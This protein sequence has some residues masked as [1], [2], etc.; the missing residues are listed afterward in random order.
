MTDAH[1][2]QG[3]RC[4]HAHCTSNIPTAT[5]TQIGG[6]DAGC[7]VLRMGGGGARTWPGTSRRGCHGDGNVLCPGHSIHSHPGLGIA[8]SLKLPLGEVGHTQ[9]HCII[10][11][12]HRYLYNYLDTKHLIKKSMNFQ[13]LFKRQGEGGKGRRETDRYTERERGR[14]FYPLA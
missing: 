7:R 6:R 13:D 1:V 14:L 11:Y 8:S 9:S 4:Q 3:G 12:N 2:S 5:T 10:S